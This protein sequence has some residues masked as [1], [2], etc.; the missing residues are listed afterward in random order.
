MVSLQKKHK[1]RLISVSS[2]QTEQR[3][4]RFIVQTG[5]IETWKVRFNGG[6]IELAPSFVFDDKIKQF[7]YRLRL[8]EYLELVDCQVDS[9]GFTIEIMT[10]DLC[11][12]NRV[13]AEKCGLLVSNFENGIGL[14]TLHLNAAWLQ[15]VSRIKC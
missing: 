4:F 11:P 14:I 7:S 15:E 9:D 6:F 8:M 10:Q 13:T 5:M 3:L 2:L 1:Q 12:I